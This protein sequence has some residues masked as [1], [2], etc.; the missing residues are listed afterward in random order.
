ECSV[1]QTAI[2]QEVHGDFVANA[3]DSAT[4]AQGDV[5]V[6]SAGQVA[7]AEADDAVGDVEHAMGHAGRRDVF[8]TGR[9]RVFGETGCEQA[10][11]GD[12]GTDPAQ[13]ARDVVAGAIG[14]GHPTQER[15]VSAVERDIDGPFTIFGDG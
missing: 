12:G 14:E 4:E 1:E 5:I 9:F 3:G 10:A 15:T 6:R 2:E 8:R 13:A 11:R 7:A